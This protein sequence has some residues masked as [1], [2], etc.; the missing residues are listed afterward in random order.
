M[1]IENIERA[2]ATTVDRYTLLCYLYHAIRSADLPR[3]VIKERSEKNLEV[4]KLTKEGQEEYYRIIDY[5]VRIFNAVHQEQVEYEDV[6]QRLGELADYFFQASSR[7]SM[8]PK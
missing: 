4:I 3:E 8:M 2:V 5:A 1:S 7:E 6:V